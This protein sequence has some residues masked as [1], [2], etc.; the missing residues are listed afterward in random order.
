MELLVDGILDRVK[1]S[2]ALGVSDGGQETFSRDSRFYADPEQFEKERQT[3][4][5]G[6]PVIAAFSCEVEEGHFKVLDDYGFPLVLTR[7][8]GQIRAFANRCRH[9]GSQLAAKSDSVRGSQKANCLVCPYHAWTYDLSGSLVGLPHERFFPGVD[10]KQLGLIPI[11]VLDQSGLVW[12]NYGSNAAPFGQDPLGLLAGDFEKLNLACSVVLDSGEEECAANWKILTES[13]LEGYHIQTTHAKSFGHTVVPQLSIQD[14]FG[15]HS[16]A[17]YPLKKVTKT[18]EL[19]R[20]TLNQKLT[21]LSAIYHLFPNVILA[22]EPYQYFLLQFIP[23]SINRTKVRKTVLSNSCGIQEPEK[24]DFERRLLSLGAKE[25]YEM[26]EQIQRNLG[27]G[28]NFSMNF[29][30]NENLIAHFHAMLEKHT[31]ESPHEAKST[32][33]R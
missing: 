29:G 28:T 30:L 21:S 15:N 4:F 14:L 22:M 32:T 13:F 7:S 18:L 9:R 11:P 23:L 5:L 2:L 3:L 31:G 27:S 1:S 33:C 6:A 19:E 16:R 8:E 20:P 26:A 10:K 24:S 12:V 17:F 25:D